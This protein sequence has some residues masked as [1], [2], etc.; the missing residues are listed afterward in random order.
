MRKPL[1]NYT[2][3]VEVER[4]IAEI[5][6][7]LVRAGASSVST[8]Y[9]SSRPVAVSFT[10]RSTLGE[11][12]YRLPARV[13]RVLGVLEA[14]RKLGE[15]APRYATKEHAARVAWRISKD[16]V[17][18]QLALA[19]SGMVDV[20]ETLLPYEVENGR[21]FFEV[22]RQRKMEALPDRSSSGR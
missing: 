20:A 2:T 12:S 10:M 7:I 18:A 8:S 1:L 15:I 11:A 22:Y 13:D 21:T 16:W 5:G 17:E 3:T 4:T 14:Q 6:K 19:A 9:E